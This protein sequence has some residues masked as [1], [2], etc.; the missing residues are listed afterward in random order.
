MKSRFPVLLLLSLVACTGKTPRENPRPE[1]I[2]VDSASDFYEQSEDQNVYDY[3][4]FQGIYD[5]ESTTQGFAAVLTLTENGNDLSF[6]LSVSQGNC[7]GEAKGTII[8]VSHEENYHIGFFEF[9]QCPLQFSLMLHEDKVDVKEV[10]LCRLH[11]SNCAFEGT[12]A[13][14]IDG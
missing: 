5:H 3:R 10:N 11:E 14:R 12:Y 1:A 4:T 7:K 9:D 6:T 2:E 8:M 13:K